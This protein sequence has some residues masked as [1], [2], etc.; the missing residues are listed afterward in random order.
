MAAAL[1]EANGAVAASLGWVWKILAD[2]KGDAAAAKRFDRR[3]ELKLLVQDADAIKRL[4]AY[5]W[6]NMS[7]SGLTPA[8]LRCI[9]YHLVYGIGTAVRIGTRL[10]DPQRTASARPA[11]PPPHPP[12]L[13]LPLQP[14]AAEKFVDNLREKIGGGQ[15]PPAELATLCAA[16]AWAEPLRPAEP[17]QRGQGRG[18][19]SFNYECYWTFLWNFPA[20]S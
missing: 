5:Q 20:S 10:S 16:P 9:F 13:S 1:K 3:E 7:C 18:P 6:Q 15:I 4:S 17:L 19:K 8:E 11:P 14:R 2:G 12:L